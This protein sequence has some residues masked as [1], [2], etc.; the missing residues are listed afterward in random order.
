MV[1]HCIAACFTS[2]SRLHSA[3]AAPALASLIM[4]E[5]RT[6]VAGDGQ[7]VSGDSSRSCVSSRLFSLCPC[8][9]CPCEPRRASILATSDSSVVRYRNLLSASSTLDTAVGLLPFLVSKVAASVTKVA[10]LFRACQ[11]R[12]TK[13][14]ASRAAAT[15]KAAMSMK[16]TSAELPAEPSTTSTLLSS[17][18]SSSANA[19]RGGDDGRCGGRGCADGGDGGGCKGGRKGSESDGGSDCDGAPGL[20][21]GNSIGGSRPKGDD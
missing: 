8:E 21:E 14:R 17:A 12:K 5:G 20:D 11:R 18:S 6:P 9:P 13:M 15:L 1:N 16:V 4:R 3:T 10:F 7:K 19:D 2:L